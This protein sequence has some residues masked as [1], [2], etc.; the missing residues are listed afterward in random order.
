M[1][2]DMRMIKMMIAALFLAAA[3]LGGCTHSEHPTESVETQLPIVTVPPETIC[4]TVPQTVPAYSIPVETPC[5]VLYLPDNWDMP[6]R[7]ES[8]LGDPMVI[9]FWAEDVMLYELTFSENADGAVGM[10]RIEDG[11][12]YVGMRLTE[13]EIEDN[14]LLSMQET[15]NELMTQLKLEDVPDVPEDTQ[16]QADI[17]IDTPYGELRFPGKW[18]NYLMTQQEEGLIDFYAALPDHEPVLLFTVVFETANGHASGVITA[19]NGTQTDLAIVIHDLELPGDWSDGEI[20]IV[21]AMQEDMNYL[22][23]KLS[24]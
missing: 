10:V 2:V 24:R 9:S 11:T 21:Y 3:L 23:N 15:I 1:K 4:E 20:D 14:M 8:I 16:P 5:G 7:T 6:I 22:L 17:P 19:Q 12:I 18:K 13:L